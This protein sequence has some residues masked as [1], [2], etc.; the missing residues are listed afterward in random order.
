MARQVLSQVFEIRSVDVAA[1]VD[2]IPPFRTSGELVTIHVLDAPAD[3]VRV[4]GSADGGAFASLTWEGPAGIAVINAVGAGIYEV[5]ER[6]MWIRVG[7]NQDVNAPRSFRV[8]LFVHVH[9]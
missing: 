6:P 5:R 4:M 3:L 9:T 2:A 8:Q 1:G 7:V